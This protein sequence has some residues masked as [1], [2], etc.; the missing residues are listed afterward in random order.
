MTTVFGIVAG[1][2]SFSAYLF[3]IRTILKGETKPN[4]ATWFIWSIIGVILVFSYKAS[5]AEETIWVPVSEAIAP[6]IIA[7]LSI[8]YGVGGTDKLDIICLI[9]SFISLLMW[10]VFDSAL[11]ALV[12]NLFIDFFAALPTIKKSIYNPK[13]EDKFAW[14]ITETGNLFNLFAINNMSFG[15][16]VYPIYTFILDGIITSLLYRK[17]K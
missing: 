17:T 7:L 4:R 9:A 14:S 2:L 11:I 1:I 12:T 13:E 6:T 10:Y 15:V 5:G 8:K 16:I 3:Y